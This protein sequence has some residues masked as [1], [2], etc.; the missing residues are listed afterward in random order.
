MND[1]I[2][3]M[4]CAATAPIE[5]EVS[6]AC[7]K[8][9]Y[10]EFGNPSSL[11]PLGDTAKSAI[12]KA[13][14]NIADLIGGNADEI[15]FTSGATESN[16]Q[17]IKT[18]AE[19]LRNIGIGNHIITTQIEH[20]SVL[21]TCRYLERNGFEVT[22]LPV[23][24]HGLINLDQ[25]KDAIKENTILVSIM[26]VNN[27]IGS[28]QPI[29]EIGEICEA[30]TIHFHT[31]VTQALGKIPIDVKELKIDFLSASAHKI[32]GLSGCGIIWHKWLDDTIHTFIH[33]GL[34]EKGLR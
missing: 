8:F 17:I 34:Q 14:R 25:L 27:E 12:E 31:D 6:N 22:Y 30:K 4:D 15:I 19:E 21:N 10:K 7:A 32:G 26:M 3:Y 11:Y 29:K 33:G 28:I 18:V 23:D 16:N 5:S 2:I 1:K 24:K 20:K 9:L 13:R